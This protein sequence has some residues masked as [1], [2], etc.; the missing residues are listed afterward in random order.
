MEE[1]HLQV[2]ILVLKKPG[3][4]AFDGEVDFASFHV[5][6][7]NVDLGGP[8]QGNLK[9]SRRLISGLAFTTH[10]LSG[11]LKGTLRPVETPQAWSEV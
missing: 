11:S 10:K 9:Q 3:C 8:L 1:D 7:S 5:L 4:P 2:V 6:S